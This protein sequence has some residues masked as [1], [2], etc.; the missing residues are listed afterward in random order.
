MS[1]GREHAYTLNV[2]SCSFVVISA[3][4]VN[5][6]L[7]AMLRTTSNIIFMVNDKTSLLF[8]NSIVISYVYLNGH[9]CT[10]ELTHLP[11]YV[12]N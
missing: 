5:N 9:V 8:L 4:P 7:H 2:E 1:Y 10:L 3:L 11:S 6:I 12:K